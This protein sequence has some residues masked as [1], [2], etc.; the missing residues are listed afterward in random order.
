[1]ETEYWNSIIK[2][3]QLLTIL[4]LNHLRNPRLH[5]ID[6]VADSRTH[7]TLP[8]STL[9]APHRFSPYINF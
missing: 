5:R 1:M 9:K 3:R 6:E 4:I 2:L 8:L 7:G